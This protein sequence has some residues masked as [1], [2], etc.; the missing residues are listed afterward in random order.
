[1][2]VLENVLGLVEPAAEFA[3]PTYF[4]YLAVFLWATS[5][6]IVGWRKGYDNVGVFVV[7]IVSAFGGGI[8][9]DGLFLQQVPPLLTEASY[10]P[11]VLAA[12]IIVILVGRR[13]QR[14]RVLPKVVSVI[15]ALGTPMFAVVGVELAIYAQLPTLSVLFVGVVSGVGGGL[16]RDVMVGNTPEL[17][18]PGQYNTLLVVLACGLYVWLSRGTGM[19]EWYSAWLTISLF[20]IA[21]MLT[22]RFNWRSRPVNEFEIRHVVEGVTGLVPL[23][24]K[25]AKETT[26]E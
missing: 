7:A 9:R 8:L 15:D 25:E 17:L 26:E 23:G 1:M 22:I 3:P 10:I 6:A 11:I 13:I 16:L 12:T 2:E 20:F 24:R 21:R 19:S 14:D 5:G 18:R 4:E